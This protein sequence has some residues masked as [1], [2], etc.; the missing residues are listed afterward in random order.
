MAGIPGFPILKSGKIQAPI[1]SLIS[2]AIGSLWSALFPG[3]KWGIY[4]AG[5]ETAKVEVDSVVELGL[6]GSAEASTYKIEAG[7]FVSYNKVRNPNAFMIRISKEGTA[8]TR[9]YI[10]EWLAT[11]VEATTTFDIVMPEKRYNGY[12]LVEYRMLR[13]SASGAGMIVADLMIQEMRETSALYSNSKIADANNVPPTP[14]ARVQL[15]EA[16][17]PIKDVQWQ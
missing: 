2:A 16:I 1:T 17:E 5:S 3:E 4:E 10:N 12:T 9:A 11:N 7:S 15:G 6:N 13:S 8:A 14:T